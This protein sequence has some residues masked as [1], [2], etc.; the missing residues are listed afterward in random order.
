MP[1]RGATDEVAVLARPPA[2]ARTA[3][4]RCGGGELTMIMDRLDDA[5]WAA[6]CVGDAWA[7]YGSA[8]WHRQPPGHRRRYVDMW[9]PGDFVV[10]AVYID[11][12]ALAIAAADRGALIVGRATLTSLVDR[13]AYAVR[14]GAPAAAVARAACEAA[15]AD[16][17][18]A[19][20]VLGSR[21]NAVAEAGGG[22][23]AA[24]GPD[25]RIVVIAGGGRIVIAH[26]HRDGRGVLATDYAP[27]R[28]ASLARHALR[29]C[30]ADGVI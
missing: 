7:A 3:V 18:H 23:F 22:W 26:D 4:A 11:G 8:A 2:P 12:S 27:P 25:G 29:L 15:R 30:A 17:S 20:D 1:P 28:L 24:S 21:R 6:R 16:L 10:A 9:A 5:A 14:G 19:A 13:W